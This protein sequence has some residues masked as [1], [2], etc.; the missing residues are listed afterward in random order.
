MEQISFLKLRNKVVLSNKAISAIKPTIL[1]DEEVKWLKRAYFGFYTE[2]IKSRGGT[3]VT[4]DKELKILS[5]TFNWCICSP[6]FNGDLQKG[7]YIASQQGWGKDIILTT[8]IKFYNFFERHFK[9]LSFHEFN[10][11]WFELGEKYFSGPV[12][13]NDINENGK[14]KRERESIPFLEFLDFREQNNLRR[15][16]IVSTNY[17]PEALQAVLEADRLVKRLNERIK[18]CFNIILIRDATSKR[19][20]NKIEI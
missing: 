1:S 20:I 11:Q 5:H 2:T 15:G 6:E 16:L 4:S 9:E 3:P 17:T 13:I 14:M 18:E 10:S 19:V 7:L 8:I 12:K